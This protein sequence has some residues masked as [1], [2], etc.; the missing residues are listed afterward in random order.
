MLRYNLLG[1]E[2]RPGMPRA[3]FSVRYRKSQAS[4][5]LS[6]RSSAFSDFWY[7]Y[8]ASD[9]AAAMAAASL[10]AIRSPRWRYKVLASEYAAGEFRESGN[11][12]TITSA[13]SA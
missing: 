7:Q 2:V 8:V 3:A 6:L 4:S 1:R 5:I 11:P 10:G 13:R 12:S 9:P